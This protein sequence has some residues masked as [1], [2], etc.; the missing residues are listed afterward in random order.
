VLLIMPISGRVN[1]ISCMLSSLKL[2]HGT[3]GL[4]SG[5]P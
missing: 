5:A 1:G 4:N 2:I 3:K